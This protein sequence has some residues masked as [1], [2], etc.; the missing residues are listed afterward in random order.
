MSFSVV[1]I[2]AGNLSS[3]LA[4]NL[5]KCGYRIVQVYSRTENSAKSVAE[6]A[7]SAWTCD[8]SLIAG[9]ADL[10]FTAL[11]DAAFHEVL[12]GTNLY[13]KTII[14][15][16]G[17]LPMSALKEYTSSYGVFYP[18][19]TF[20]RG[21][22]VDFSQIPVFIE[23]SSEE[24]KDKLTIM[25]GRLN[26]AVHYAD[27]RQ[28]LSLHIAAVFACNFVNHFYTV[29]SAILEKHQLDFSLI[30]PLM[31]ETL[32]KATVMPPFAAQTGPAV[33]F[34]TNI[35]TRHLEALQGDPDLRNIYEIVSQHIYKL[36][37]I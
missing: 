30:H 23:S 22:P 17:S 4:V 37:Q 27:S 32:R 19:Q 29:A 14:H 20:T 16:S 18:L 5:S 34:D 11:K 12:S 33:R 9:D 15:C 35:I 2:G 3:H 25:A 28:R 8:P 21:V 26:A 1:F 31:K 36:H 24:V 6:S 7:G 13:G 10:Y